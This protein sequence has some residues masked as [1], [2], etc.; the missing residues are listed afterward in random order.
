MGMDEKGVDG[1]LEQ[2]IPAPPGQEDLS[3]NVGKLVDRLLSKETTFFDHYRLRSLGGQLEAEPSPNKPNNSE[4]YKAF[5]KVFRAAPQTPAKDLGLQANASGRPAS[6]PRAITQATPPK[7]KKSLPLEDKPEDSPKAAPEAPHKA[8]APKDR[9]QIK[10]EPGWLGPIKWLTRLFFSFLALAWIFV[11]GFIVGRATLDQDDA[12]IKAIS[13]LSGNEALADGA[14]AIDDELEPITEAY[15]VVIVSPK[16]GTRPPNY[17]YWTAFAGNSPA[18]RQNGPSQLGNQ[19]VT[20][21]RPPTWTPP[22]DAHAAQ[23][24]QRLPESPALEA[25]SIAARTEIAAGPVAEPSTPA[26]SGTARAAMAT[27]TAAKP[28]PDD[29]EGFWPEKPVRPGAYTIQVGSADT[30]EEARNM[31]KKFAAKGFDDAYCYKT[32][33]G[34]FNVRVGRYLTETEGRT[35][36]VALAAAG[37]VQ[38]YVSKLNL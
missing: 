18:A 34:R 26:D 13:A 2:G 3:L 27:E 25:V 8:T 16:P 37:A 33:S 35:A 30:E 36:A 5:S 11:L 4:M 29:D 24:P 6:K 14:P 38:P 10:V 12:P 9:A 15:P 19:E 1:K 28:A 22:K 23:E 31:V 21:D 7:L 17:G 20:A 32:R